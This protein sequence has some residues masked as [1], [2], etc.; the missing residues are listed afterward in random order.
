MDDISYG[1]AMS[2]IMQ[3][4][5]TI[6]FNVWSDG[7]CVLSRNITSQEGLEIIKG[8]MRAVIRHNNV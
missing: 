3:K 6:D 7:E 1:V 4:Y 2:A 8:A 5:D